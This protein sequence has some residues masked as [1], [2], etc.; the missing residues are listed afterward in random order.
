MS[1]QNDAQTQNASQEQHNGAPSEAG[2]TAPADGDPSADVGASQNTQEIREAEETDEE[3]DLEAATEDELKARLRALEA[4]RNELNDRLLR[5]AA[6][7]QNFRKRMQREKK[8]FYQSGK[9]D[10][11]LP[12][13][14]VL[15]DF[16]RSLEAAEE[17]EEKQDIE[18]AYESLKSGV[19]MIFQKFMDELRS[20]GVEPIEAEGKPFD[21]HE[22]E[23]MMQQPAPEGVEEGIVLSEV[24]KGYRLDDQVLRHSRVIVSS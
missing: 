6:E 9:K 12:L 1:N 19:G 8:R 4:E 10:V 20:V 7:F 2:D 18:T 22:H 5:R 14:E 15:D 17:L 16:Q 11:V 21:E 3:F 24:R 23:A 13:L